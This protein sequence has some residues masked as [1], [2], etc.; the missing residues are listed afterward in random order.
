MLNFLKKQANLTYTE[1]GGLTYSTT[2][3]NC[4]DLFFRAGGM[5]DAKEKEILDI[6][7]SAYI[8]VAGNVFD[9]DIIKFIKEN[10]FT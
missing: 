7:T 10:S 1:N 3:N 5:R 6:V 8:R 2:E 9:Q 4:L